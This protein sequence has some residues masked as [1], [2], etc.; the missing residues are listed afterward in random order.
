MLLNLVFIKNLLN[1]DNIENS[2]NNLAQQ[3]LIPK[4]I[5]RKF[6]TTAYEYQS[7]LQQCF[8]TDE[9][10]DKLSDEKAIALVKQALLGSGE[11]I[12]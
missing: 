3:G 9:D 1:Y 5:A 12:S 4:S 11:E 8:G 2:I 6:L 10:S 7:K